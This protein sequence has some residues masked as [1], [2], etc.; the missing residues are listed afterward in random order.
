MVFTA[1]S[2][3]LIFAAIIS[4]IE[5]KPITVKKS[6]TWDNTRVLVIALNVTA[7]IVVA[8]T[9]VTTLTA[10]ASVNSTSDHSKALISVI[11]FFTV[12]FLL[13]APSH[14]L[15]LCPIIESTI[16][17]TVIF[18]RDKRLPLNHQHAALAMLLYFVYNHSTYTVSFSECPGNLYTL[19]PMF[20]VSPAMTTLTGT[21]YS[22]SAPLLGSYKFSTNQSNLSG[23]LTGEP[24]YLSLS[25]VL[26][27][28]KSDI[29]FYTEQGVENLSYTLGL[30]LLSLISASLKAF[31]RKIKIRPF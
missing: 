24:H 21:A 20:K 25:A 14:L 19:N 1:L 26:N 5:L 18:F 7:L 10:L 17:S 15:P 9:L 29:F 4:L 28:S 30:F 23:V 13:S 6:A 31:S 12:C 11:I 16:I 3:L 27:S 22:R 2:T 8:Y